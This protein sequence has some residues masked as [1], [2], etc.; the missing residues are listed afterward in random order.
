MADPVIAF[1]RV[2]TVAS[3][4][5]EVALA[6]AEACRVHGLASADPIVFAAARAHDAD[7]LACNRL[8]ES[9]PGLLLALET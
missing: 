4:G 5:T 6:T 8:F 7:L 1:T 9:L 3:V 2:C